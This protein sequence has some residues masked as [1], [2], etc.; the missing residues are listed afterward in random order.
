MRISVPKI[1]RP[2]DLADYAPELVRPDGKPALVWVW[3]NPPR[4]LMDRRSRQ[5]QVGADAYRTLAGS[6]PAAG[7][8]T[9]TDDQRRRIMS[10]LHATGLEMASWFAEI[11]SQHSDAETHWTTDDVTTLGINETDP[12]LYPWLQRRTLQLIH[13]HRDAEKKR[14]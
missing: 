7:G 10:D 6:L 1:M 8:Q 4:D 14:P 13:E 9:L 2:I 5:I 3:V 11:W 12:S